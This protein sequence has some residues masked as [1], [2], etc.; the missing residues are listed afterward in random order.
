MLL[1]DTDSRFLFLMR[2]FCFDPEPE[3][4]VGRGRLF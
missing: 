3:E 1:C 4:M 2:D